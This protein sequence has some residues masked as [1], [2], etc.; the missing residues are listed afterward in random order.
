MSRLVTRSTRRPCSAA[1]SASGM[2]MPKATST[3]SVETSSGSAPAVKIRLSRSRPTG[4]VPS[5]WAPEGSA[6]RFA[7]S[8][9]STSYGRHSGAVNDARSASTSQPAPKM[10]PGRRRKHGQA[11]ALGG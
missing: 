10:P 2:P 9:S 7:R 1:I 6:S 4:S 8:C 3:V 5:Q 11:A